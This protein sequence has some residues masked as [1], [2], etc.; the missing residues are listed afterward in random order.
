[1]NCKHCGAE[2]Y[3]TSRFCPEC[4]EPVEKEEAAAE[5]EIQAAETVVDNS[6]DNTIET[7]SDNLN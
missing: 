1:M 6:A 2:L 3:E 5:P 7:S 4:G